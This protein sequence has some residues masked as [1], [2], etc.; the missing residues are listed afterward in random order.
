MLPPS[1]GIAMK[2][3]ETAGAPRM[4]FRQVRVGAVKKPRA[5]PRSG[6]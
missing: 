2:P 3:I 5:A 6:Q 4:V 1:Q